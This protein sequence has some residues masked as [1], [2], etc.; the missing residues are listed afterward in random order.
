MISLESAR[1]SKAVIVYN[2]AAGRH[3]Q[4]E[5]FVRQLISSASRLGMSVTGEPT[6][7]PG[8]ATR[9]AAAAVAEGAELVVSYGGDGTANEV[10]QALAGTATALGVWPGGTANV[11]AGVL[12]MPRNPTAMAERMAAGSTRRISLGKAGGRYFLLMAGIGLDASVVAGVKPIL[13]R[14][15][16]E[17]AFALSA[18]EHLVQWR[19]S[20]FAIQWEEGAEPSAGSFAV[21]G[22][23]SG[24][25]GGF[26]IT[27]GARLEEPSLEVCLFSPET[28]AA[29]LRYLVPAWLG[30]HIGMRGV[31]CRKV[32]QVRV[33]GTA[34]V[35]VDGELA[36]HLPREFCSVPDALELL[37]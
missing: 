8:D 13:K 7:G 34:P 31:T 12:G 2:P 6:Q 20:E 29:Y 33:A 15:L 18:L 36:G 4:R 28:R 27:P 1:F 21:I 11:L 3:G 10:V 23:C 5:R 30:R 17:G 25:G 37:V 19:P 14:R 35:Q 16:G 9:I 26:R 32:S 24:Y 22:N